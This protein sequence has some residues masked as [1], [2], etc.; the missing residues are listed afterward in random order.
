MEAMK[1]EAAINAPITGVVKRVVLG[2]TT[3]LDGG[4]LVTVIE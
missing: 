2:G 4:D 3:Q 1:M